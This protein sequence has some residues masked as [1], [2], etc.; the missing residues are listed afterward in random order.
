MLP[1]D[2]INPPFIS[3]T[4]IPK[5]ADTRPKRLYYFTKFCIYFI[6][7]CFQIAKPIKRAYG[8]VIGKRANWVVVN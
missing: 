6:A 5:N 2:S 4:P 7:A 1:F 3:N 8:T